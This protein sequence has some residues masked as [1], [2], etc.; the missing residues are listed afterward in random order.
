[1][2]PEERPATGQLAPLAAI[3]PGP[4]VTGGEIAAVLLHV[5]GV[6]GGV[7]LVLGHADHG[8]LLVDG[9][10]SGEADAAVEIALIVAALLVRDV[11][12]EATVEIDVGA[13][14]GLIDDGG[15]RRTDGKQG[16]NGQGKHGLFHCCLSCVGSVPEPG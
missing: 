2:S 10:A 11:E 1:M 7:D 6:F 4:D 15:L 9:L 5:V 14:I 13:V 16:R 8:H 12:A 3:E